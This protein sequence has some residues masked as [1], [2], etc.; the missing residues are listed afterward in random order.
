MLEC[1]HPLV[2][3]DYLIV[4]VLIEVDFLIAF[5]SLIVALATDLKR[6]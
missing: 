2:E 3:F 6:T 1:L 5:V 4:V